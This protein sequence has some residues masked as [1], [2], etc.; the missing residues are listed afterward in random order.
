MENEFSKF[1]KWDF[2]D[3]IVQ[4]VRLPINSALPMHV[5]E[6]LAT[7]FPSGHIQTPPSNEETH[8]CSH[9]SVEHRDLAAKR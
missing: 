3:P 9:P 5:L 1:K 6:S 8:S 7:F 4:W 2:F